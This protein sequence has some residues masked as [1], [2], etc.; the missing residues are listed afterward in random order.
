MATQQE[1]DD[2]KAPGLGGE[3]RPRGNQHPPRASVEP[4]EAL[5]PVVGLEEQGVEQVGRSRVHGGASRI[6]I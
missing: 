4:S 3:V 1:L 2:L 6:W 5:L